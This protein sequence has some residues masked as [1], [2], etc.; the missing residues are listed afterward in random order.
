VI[1]QGYARAHGRLHKVRVR[2][3]KDPGTRILH[4][5]LHPANVVL[6]AAGPVVIDWNN[7]GAGDPGADVARTMITIAGAQL[8]GPVR[9]RLLLGAIRGLF[10]AVF[11]RAA[12]VDPRPHLAGAVAAKLADPNVTAAERAWLQLR[13][14]PQ[15]PAG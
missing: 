12:G 15:P 6:T 8:E 9:V 2:A 1:L 4:L 5:D 11:R 14:E 13:A 10:V 3:A 7:V